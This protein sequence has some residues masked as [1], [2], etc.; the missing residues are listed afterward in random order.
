MAR[1]TVTKLDSN[2]QNPT[3]RHP[4]N[5]QMQLN[6]DATRVATTAF[7]N[8]KN[9]IDSPETR[10]MFPVGKCCPRCMALPG[11]KCVGLR[12]LLS[13]IP[14]FSRERTAADSYRSNVRARTGCQLICAVGNASHS[15]MSCKPR[16]SGAEGDDLPL[17]GGRHD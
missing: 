15:E 12:G 10:I 7:R 9:R 4:T 2:E 3:A 1:P 11:Y 6:I 16:P 8:V 5:I 13:P 14:H 17:C